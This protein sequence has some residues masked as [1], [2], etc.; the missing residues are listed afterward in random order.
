MHLVI[1]LF[2]YLFI[3][4]SNGGSKYSKGLEHLRTREQ[5]RTDRQPEKKKVALADG[6]KSLRHLVFPGGLPSKY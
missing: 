3:L 1:Y 5:A 2:I 6:E 4:L